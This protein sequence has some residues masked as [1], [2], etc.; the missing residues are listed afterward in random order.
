MIFKLQIIAMVMYGNSAMEVLLLG[1]R[2]LV[3]ANV[4][5]VGRSFVKL[6]ILTMGV[7]LNNSFF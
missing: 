7:V 1:A 6:L 3:E 2:A 5:P 4:M